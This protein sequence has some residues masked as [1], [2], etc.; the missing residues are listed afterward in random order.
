MSYPDCLERCS[1]QNWNR[2]KQDREWETRQSSR[3]DKTLPAAPAWLQLYWTTFVCQSIIYELYTNN[4]NAQHTTTS[5]SCTRGTW[6]APTTTSACETHVSQLD[7]SLLQQI[8]RAMFTRCEVSLACNNRMHA[9][10]CCPGLQL[11]NASTHEPLHVF[12]LLMLWVRKLNNLWT[13]CCWN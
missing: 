1:S 2:H 7:S 6:V 3:G 9:I 4:G 12:M 10:S 13:E 5:G 8:Y 11:C